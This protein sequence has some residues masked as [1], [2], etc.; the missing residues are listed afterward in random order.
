[1]KNTF[2]PIVCIFAVSSVSAV[3]QVTTANNSSAGNQA[4][5]V[6]EQRQAIIDSLPDGA[7]VAPWAA[8]PGQMA[9]SQK[10]TPP[11]G[12]GFSR[13]YSQTLPSD[14]RWWRQFDDPILNDLINKAENANFNIRQALR[15]MQLAKLTIDEAKSG[16]YPTISASAGYTVDRSAGAI[17]NPATKGN[18]L[19][20]MDLGLSAQW[21]IDLFGR[22]HEQLKADKAS[23][24]LSKAD[25]DAAML[26]LC[27]ELAK[28]YIQLRVLQGQYDLAINHTRS[29]EAIVNM[30][31]ARQ[32][33]GL[34]S[35]LEVAQARQVLYSTQA[36]IPPLEA[37][38][39]A[40]IGAIA[41][42]VGEYP[43]EVAPTLEESKPLPD[44]IATP[45]VGTPMEMLR[46]RPDIAQAEAEMALYA[47]Q[48]G[49]A[50]K[51]YLPTLTL[52][53]NIGVQAHKP[54]DLFTS[55]GF[56][57]SV[58]PTLSWTVFDGLSRKYRTAAAREQ[59]EASID[60][61][62]QTL[63]GAVQEVDTYAAQYQAY[64]HQI[65]M[66]KKL[67][68]ESQTALDL[69][70]DLYR[71]TLTDFSNVVDAQMSLL[72]YQNEAIT[73]HGDALTALISLYQAL[74]GGW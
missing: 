22:I 67:V 10:I 17:T 70:V 33:A 41:V 51:D 40:T 65:S 32:E 23:L 54:G 36:S 68:D 42:L 44:V 52:S 6:A 38:I 31:L 53:G 9:D 16:Y 15:R 56:T 46:R 73:A 63:L 2:L 3:A 25:Y 45:M 5:S 47:A 50:K 11:E 7:R 18:T 21:E 69:S 48:L 43:D 55:K 4:L 14:D 26:S 27:S 28:D 13:V 58:A 34:A 64:L 1:M 57:Y 19:T 59:M 30:T 72:E 49:V 37:Q 12:W 35:A 74:G 29:Q 20:Y 39:Q 61:Y 66:L 24:T 60:N 71:S 62:N 8:G